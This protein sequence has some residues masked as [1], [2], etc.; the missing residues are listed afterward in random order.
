M[1][2]PF[3]G[4]CQP[5]CGPSALP[6]DVRPDRC[7]YK[8]WTCGNYHRRYGRVRLRTIQACLVQLSISLFLKSVQI[9]GE[10]ADPK[11]YRSCRVAERLACTRLSTKPHLL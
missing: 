7:D 11:A 5:Y 3:P 2:P 6:F 4:L 9:I 8:G 10:G 1:C